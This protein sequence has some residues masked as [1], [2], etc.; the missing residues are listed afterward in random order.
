MKSTS[1]SGLHLALL[2]I[3]TIAVIVG[4]AD[5][6]ASDTTAPTVASTVPILDA[7]AVSPAGNVSATFSEDMEAA[8]IIAANFTLAGGASVAGTVSYDV[9][10]MTATFAPTSLLESGTVYTATVTIGAKDMGGNALAVN[11]VWTFTTAAA[12]VGPEP[13]LLGTAGNYAILAKTGVST[14]PSS[15]ITGDIGLSPA[16]ETMLTGFSQTD[17]TGYATSAQVTGF[18]YAADMADPTPALMTT[19]IS[20][21]E[22]AYT[23]A[24][25]RVTPDF[26]DLNTG[27]IGG[28]TLAPGLYTWASSVSAL[29]DFTIDG[30]A[31]DVWIFQMSGDLSVAAGVQVTLSG[32]AQAS[33]IFW[34]VAG[35]T[36]LGTTSSFAGII[37]CSTAIALNTG[38]TVNG[39]LLAQSAVTLDQSAVVEPA[40]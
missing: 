14:V 21:M 25:G 12:G 35:A 7:I 8:T 3:L 15:T 1:P 39:R 32:G 27:E 6:V 20:D 10:T 31:N 9:P 5:P 2:A 13:V 16:A 18:L 34:Q 24:A 17:A 30:A 26:T 37:L 36:S 28:E 23:D 33:N 11:K 4:C 29:T 19:A 22:T 40:N 38:A